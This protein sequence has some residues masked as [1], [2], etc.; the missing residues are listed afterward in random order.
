[1]VMVGDRA[2]DVRGAKECG[3]RSI[4]AAW[5]FGSEE[6][7]R[8]AEPDMTVRSMTELVERLPLLHASSRP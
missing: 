5:G 1:M 7:L 2:E 6:E 8:L 4:A 3:I